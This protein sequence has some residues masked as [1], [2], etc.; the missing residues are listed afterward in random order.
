VRQTIQV[1]HNGILL[2]QQR[3]GKLTTRLASLAATVLQ[4]NVSGVD[5]FCI[6]LKEVA[7]LGELYQLLLEVFVRQQHSP[8]LEHKYCGRDWPTLP[9]YH[10]V[11]DRQ[12]TAPIDPHDAVNECTAAGLPSVLDDV[13]RHIKVLHHVIVA[14]F[15]IELD[16]AANSV[17]VEFGRSSAVS[18]MKSPKQYVTAANE[19]SVICRHHQQRQSLSL[20]F[21]NIIYACDF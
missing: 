6:E 19:M 16:V 10:C 8:L 12:R 15:R 20:T 14:I 9:V 11:C 13:K 21:V 18:A 5:L 7:S 2:R 4:L 3:T 1:S 17:T